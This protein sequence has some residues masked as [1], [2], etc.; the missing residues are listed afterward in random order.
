VYDPHILDR[1]SAKS[2]DAL[3]KKSTALILATDHREFKDTITPALLKKHKVRVFIDG[4]NAF[5]KNLFRKSGI[6]YKG[7]GR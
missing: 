3:L 2:L 6:I 1:S 4:K 7:I 5:D